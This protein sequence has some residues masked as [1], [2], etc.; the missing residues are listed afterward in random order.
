MI[1]IVIIGVLAAI[2][3]PAYKN[4]VSEA[5][6]S[7]CDANKRTIATAMGMYYVENEGYPSNTGD[8]SGFVTNIAEISKCPADDKPLTISTDGTGDSTTFKVHCDT[9]APDLTVGTGKVV[10]VTP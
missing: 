10:N 7:A 2:G 8:L 9:H 4:Y 6:K 5:R 1:V 3:V